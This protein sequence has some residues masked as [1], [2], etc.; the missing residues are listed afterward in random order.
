M[1]TSVGDLIYDDNGQGMVNA[2]SRK[3]IG[4]PWPLMT[5]G[6]NASVAYKGFDIAMVFS[7]AFG[8]DIMNL[9]KPYTHMFMSLFDIQEFLP[10]L[11]QQPML[12]QTDSD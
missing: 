1:N 4:N 6:I 8:F 9:V 5:M 3:Y 7:G 10:A 2:A 11:I 12:Y